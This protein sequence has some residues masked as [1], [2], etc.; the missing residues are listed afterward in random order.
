[1]TDGTKG[2]TQPSGWLALAAV[3]SRSLLLSKNTVT[4]PPARRA[5]AAGVIA[6]MK[7]SRARVSTKSAANLL[8]R[9]ISKMPGP[10]AAPRERCTFMLS[11]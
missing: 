10:P 8:R 7:V 6:A 11:R 1:M 2:I 3:T 9:G 4:V 5:A